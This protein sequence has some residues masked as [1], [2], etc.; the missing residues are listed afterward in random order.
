MITDVFLDQKRVNVCKHMV[1]V[2]P[3]ES[4]LKVP[5]GGLRDRKRRVL[6]GREEKL[7]GNY[8]RLIRGLYLENITN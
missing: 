5:I 8:L 7:N 3:H 6:E 1:K 4:F 2:A